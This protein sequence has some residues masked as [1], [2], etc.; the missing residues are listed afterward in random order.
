VPRRRLSVSAPDS[1]AIA[2]SLAELRQNL[3]VSLQF[4]EDVLADAER[5]VR[6]G[7]REGVHDEDESIV[8]G[9]RRHE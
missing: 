1:A 9:R 5:A 8:R 2:A 6:E 3:D 4:P 7:V